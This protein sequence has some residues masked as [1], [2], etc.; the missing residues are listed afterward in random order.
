MSVKHSTDGV[1]NSKWLKL[2]YFETFVSTDKSCIRVGSEDT[3]DSTHTG[4]P[5]PVDSNSTETSPF[6]FIAFR[7]S[8]CGSVPLSH[9]WCVYSV[10]FSFVNRVCCVCVGKFYVVL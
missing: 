6:V 5:G 8:A 7:F 9:V 4:V 2:F 3:R 1:G 10:S